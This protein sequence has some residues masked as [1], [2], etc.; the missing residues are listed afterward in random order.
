MAAPTATGTASDQP[1]PPAAAPAIAPLSRRRRILVWT[2]VVV[3]SLLAVVSI[4]TTWVNR[5]MLDDTAWT[6]ATTQVIQDPKVQTAI[7]TY[8]INQLY[9]NIDVAQALQQRLPPNLQSLASPLA[10]ALEQPATQGVA[11]LLQRPR[12]QQRFI[13]ASTIAHQKLV[14]VLENKTG[15]GISTGN[16]VVTLDLHQMIVDVGTELGLPADALAKL[17]A[18]A[19]TLTLMRSDQLSAAQT[20]VRAIR[21]LSV[22]LLVLV[23]FL[24]GLAIYLAR[25]SRRATLRN[26]GVS[27]VLVGL[28]VLIVRRL[29]GNYIVDA[30]A[31]PGYNT[32][33]H[34]LWLIGTSILGQI[35]A[36]TIL[37]GAIAAL[38]AVFAGPTSL[39][40]RLRRS[41]APVLNERQEIVWGVVGFVYLLAVLW[42]GT[43]ALRTWW[44]I[45]LLG[46]LVAIG[47]VALRRQTLRE[48]PPGTSE[49]GMPLREPLA[50]APRP[51]GGGPAT[52]AAAA[53]AGGS[54]SPADEIARL[55]ELHE[56]GAITDDEFER[57]KRIA[58]T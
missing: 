7:A 51:S 19:G 9:S 27:F 10:G 57:A 8:T 31:T 32:A 21:V 47:V 48:F 16:G 38:G 26:A 14:N 30:L 41:L 18:K 28:V 58:L 3:A 35:G 12:I 52:A 40:T 4:L 49:E 17:P 20:G 1:R 34:H 43:H 45:L 11:F 42:G 2:L 13:Q 46:A 6:K 50:A 37:Y 44:G 36:A 24:Y 29:L 5:Q 54:R 39:A 56:T 53:P 55:K 23:L 22:W 25:G 15:Y 33:T